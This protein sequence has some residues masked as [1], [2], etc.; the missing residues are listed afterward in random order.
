MRSPLLDLLLSAPTTMES[1][2]EP[3]NILDQIDFGNS[4]LSL[5]DEQLSF[6]C[7][8]FLNEDKAGASSNARAPQANM[9]GTEAGPPDISVQFS[10]T[11]TAAFQPSNIPNYA[12]TWPSVEGTLGQNDSLFLSGPVP[13]KRRAILQDDLFPMRDQTQGQS[14]VMTLD[15]E[16]KR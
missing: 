13:N 9:D 4:S 16:T 14:T 2:F 12:P 15:E 10:P 7:S 6:L 3:D 5:N 1:Y 8:N 11:L